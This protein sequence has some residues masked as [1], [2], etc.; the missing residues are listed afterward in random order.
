MGGLLFSEEK[1]RALGRGE[2]RGKD[3]EEKREE[4]LPSGCEVN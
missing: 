4:K 1:E 3:W 2:V